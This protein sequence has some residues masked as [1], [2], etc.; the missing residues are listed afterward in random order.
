[1]PSGR[2]PDLK[3]REQMLKLRAAGLSL[4]QIGKRLGISRQRVQ[5]ALS[6]SGKLRI[7]P[8][9]CRACGNVITHLRTVAVFPA[10]PPSA[11]GSRHAAC[12]LGG[13]A[14]DACCS[15]ATSA[16]GASLG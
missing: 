3:R 12:L 1:M 5:K 13:A 4:A 2:R 14:W 11:N 8:I 10:T 6:L 9:R 7:V 16:G 15:A